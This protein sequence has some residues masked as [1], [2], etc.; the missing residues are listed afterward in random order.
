[1]THSCCP[2][3][4]LRF[5]REEPALASC[6][7]CLGPMR[8]LPAATLVGYRLFGSVHQPLD[9]VAVEMAMARSAAL[10]P[11]PHR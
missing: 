7:F 2:A 6:P 10:I 4:R 1:M 11:E 5:S 9:D 8:T 3:C